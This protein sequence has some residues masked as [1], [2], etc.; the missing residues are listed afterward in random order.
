MNR[1][2][3]PQP[4]PWLAAKGPKCR[5]GARQLGDRIDSSAVACLTPNGQRVR[6]GVLFG[7]SDRESSVVMS[8]EQAQAFA[9]SILS[10]CGVVAHPPETI[11]FWGGGSFSVG[12]RVSCE[13]K[14]FGTVIDVDQYG[15][16]T[17]RMD[18]PGAPVAAPEPP[19]TGP[20]PCGG[21]WGVCTYH[22]GPQT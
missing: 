15:D 10:I 5:V 20:C 19:R 11:T 6:V 7:P 18:P 2:K 21:T 3:P 8:V 1:R 13:G 14:H 22:G 4:S 16:C 12:D 9:R 17:V